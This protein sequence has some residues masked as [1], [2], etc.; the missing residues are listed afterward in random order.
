MHACRL[1][2]IKNQDGLINLQ[3]NINK[4]CKI[5]EQQIRCANIKDKNF[6]ARLSAKILRS[7]SNVHIFCDFNHSSNSLNNDHKVLLI[8]SVN[9]YYVKIRCFHLAKEQNVRDVYVRKKLTK[10]VHFKNQ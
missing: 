3:Q 10:L 9:D 1:T 7:V 2:V 4:I 8:K 5:A 6:F